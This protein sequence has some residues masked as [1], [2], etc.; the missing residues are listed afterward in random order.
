MTRESHRKAPLPEPGKALELLEMLEATLARE[1]VRKVLAGALLALDEEGLER[2][3]ARLGGEVASTLRAVL[4]S[5]RGPVDGQPPPPGRGKVAEEWQRTIEDWDECIAE[6]RG[7]H[8]RFIEQEASWEP[9]YLAVGELA[10]ELDAI[11]ARLR[12]MIGPAVSSG[13]VNDFSFGELLDESLGEIGGDLPEWMDGW[14]AGDLFGPEVTACLVEWELCTGAAGWH[15]A[16]GQDA[17]QAVERVRSREAAWQE[18]GLDGDALSGVVLALAAD[19]QQEVLAGIDTHVGDPS[20]QED[21]A[22]VHGHWFRLYE[23]LLARHA[24]DRHIDL[25]RQRIAEDWRLALPV[26][27]RLLAQGRAAEAAAVAGEAAQALGSALRREAAQWSPL[28]TLLAATPAW[29]VTA[30]DRDLVPRLLELWTVAASAAGDPSLAAIAEA[31]AAEAAAAG[32]SETA[33]LLYRQWRSLITSRLGHSE[34]SWVPLLA[35]AARHGADPISFQAALRRWIASA[36][37]SPGWKRE[38]ATLTMDIGGA[39]LVAVSPTLH[40]VLKNEDL[41][42]EKEARA[43]LRAGLTRFGAEA[44]LDDVI[45]GWRSNLRSLIPDPGAVSGAAYEHCADWLQV[46][47][48]LDPPL[49][50]VILDDWRRLHRRR[51]NLW[52]ALANRGITR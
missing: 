37:A 32:R 28:H 43:S 7:E 42:A 39:G 49:F 24:P 50:D 6:S 35:D 26:I 48:E 5:F 47:R 46:A 10:R 33:D 30:R 12:P 29:F 38:L 2:L 25:C 16:G 22:P 17:F 52:Q 34:R 3:S 14:D 19:A 36:S 11:A 23:A 45:A 20:W 44:C 41:Y 8:G 31:A 40:R 13:L 4:R 21:L 15:G 18:A 9:P 27:E 51:R 1:E